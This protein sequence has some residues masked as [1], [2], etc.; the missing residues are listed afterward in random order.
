MGNVDIVVQTLLAR[1]YEPYIYYFLHVKFD[2]LIYLQQ[3]GLELRGSL[4]PMSSLFFS[5]FIFLLIMQAMGSITPI[6]IK[7]ISIT[8]IVTGNTM[9]R[10]KL[11]V[12]LSN[13][14]E[15]V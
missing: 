10:F 12:G 9:A 5:N 7:S 8:V 14:L 11:V 2:T 3:E 4:E 15:L 13:V 6:T 1:V